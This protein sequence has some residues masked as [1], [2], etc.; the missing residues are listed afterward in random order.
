MQTNQFLNFLIELGNRIRT[1]KPALFVRLQWITGVLGALTGLPSFITGTLGFTI[2]PVYH[3][4]ESKIIAS[5]CTGFFIASQLT[6]ASTVTATK[7]GAVLKA[8]DADK[9]P[10]TA[11]IECK[12]AETTGVPEVK[13]TR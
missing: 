12:K 13:E 3:T 6:S 11:Q 10:F 1:K 8:T 2:P 5:I 7:D 9:L 4:L